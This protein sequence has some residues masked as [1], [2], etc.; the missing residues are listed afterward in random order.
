MGR[1]RRPAFEGRIFGRLERVVTA[2]VEAGLNDRASPPPNLAER[3]QH[4][5][6][7]AFVSG[8]DRQVLQVIA[9]GRRLLGEPDEPRRSVMPST[10]GLVRDTPEPR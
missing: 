9:S 7:V 3:L 5:E 1:R 10:S 4:L 6:R 2:L 8:G